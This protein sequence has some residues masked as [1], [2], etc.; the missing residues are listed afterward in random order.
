MKADGADIASS[1]S[2]SLSGFQSGDVDLTDGAWCGLANHMTR[3]YNSCASWGNIALSLPQ[4][5]KI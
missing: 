3:G 5:P 2:E 1:F 4:L